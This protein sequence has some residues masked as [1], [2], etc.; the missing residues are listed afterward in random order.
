MSWPILQHF[1]HTQLRRLDF[2][3]NTHQICHKLLNMINI[4]GH[5][6]LLRR[7]K[8]QHI[9]ALKFENLHL[10]KEVDTL[11][12]GYHCDRP[13]ADSRGYWEPPDGLND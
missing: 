7:E 12:H 4:F 11:R 13:A 3:Q 1:S 9:L 2:Q 6:L 10:L 8:N 5:K